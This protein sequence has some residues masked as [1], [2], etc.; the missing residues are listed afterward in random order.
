MSAWL[1]ALRAYVDQVGLDRAGARIGCSAATASQVLSGKYGADT[2]R[3]ER[4]VRGE[5][6]RETC[7]CPVLLEPTLRTCQDVQDAGGYEDIA[8]PLRARAW[9]ACRGRGHFEKAGPC[10]HF[11]GAHKAAKPPPKEAS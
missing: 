9:L 10:V 3:I 4:R 6:L 2:L 7:E 11:N 8:N 1:D 5:L